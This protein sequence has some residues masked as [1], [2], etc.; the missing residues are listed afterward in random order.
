MSENFRETFKAVLLAVLVVLFWTLV[1]KV[2]TQKEG[3]SSFPVEGGI[4]LVR[5]HVSDR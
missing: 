3:G 4:L 5:G 1:N 2:D